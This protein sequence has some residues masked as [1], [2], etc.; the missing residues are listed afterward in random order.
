MREKEREK[1]RVKE[2]ERERENERE[3]ERESEREIHGERDS[4]RKRAWRTARFK[5][6]VTER[7]IGSNK[8][9]RIIKQQRGKPQQGH[10]NSQQAKR[11]R[12][13]SNNKLPVAG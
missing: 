6:L 11:V 5:L 4:N 12:R 8:Q 10:S 13:A 2:R 1:V 3:S 9:A 7:R